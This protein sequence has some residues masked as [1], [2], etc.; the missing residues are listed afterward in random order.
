LSDDKTAED[1]VEGGTSKVL[2]RPFPKGVSGNPGGRPKTKPLTDAYRKNLGLVIT[3]ENAKELRLPAG[4]IGKTVAEAI[5]IGQ[6]KAAIKGGTIAAREI[7]D[8]TEGR[9][10]QDV[11]LQVGRLFERMT[12]EEL[13]AYARDGT[14]PDWVQTAG[15]TDGVSGA[16]E[17]PEED[18]DS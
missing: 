16:E 3:A 10:A 17:N 15:I 13:E 11:R 2:G 14:L 12:S 1:G 9:T 4:F 18:F 7:A 6:A 5:A 8:R